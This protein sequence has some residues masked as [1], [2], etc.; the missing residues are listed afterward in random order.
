LG[1]PISAPLRYFSASVLIEATF[2]RLRA[3]EE[4]AGTFGG[5]ISQAELD[6]MYTAHKDRNGAYAPSSIAWVCI[7]ARSR[8]RHCKHITGNAALDL[9]H[10]SLCGLNLSGFQV[11][12]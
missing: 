1:I 6:S 12:L 8:C 3:L 4:A 9:S 11:R 5:S 7:F 10:L 2:L